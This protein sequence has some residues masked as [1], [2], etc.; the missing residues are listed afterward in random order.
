[1]SIIIIYHN[2]YIEIYKK[3]IKYHN[4][5]I[6]IFDKI[7]NIIKDNDINGLDI[8]LNEDNLELNIS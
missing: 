1:M 8:I 4:D 7:N 5:L 6:I 2:Q 3:L